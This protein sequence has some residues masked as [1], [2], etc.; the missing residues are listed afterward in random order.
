MNDAF[1]R[2]GLPTMLVSSNN[3]QSYVSNL[4]KGVLK[5][6]GTRESYT[7]PYR[8]ASQVVYATVKKCITGCCLPYQGW[9]KRVP[10]VGSAT[11][12]SE[13]V[14]TSYASAFLWSPAMGTLGTAPQDC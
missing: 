9:N 8:L 5:H 1:C 12:T 13:S 14:V 7:V 10:E 6:W 3:T 11:F 2:H 4:Q